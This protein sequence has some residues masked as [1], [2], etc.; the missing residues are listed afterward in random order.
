MTYWLHWN[1]HHWQKNTIEEVKSFIDFWRL[2]PRQYSVE[3]FEA[4]NGYRISPA[5]SYTG[6]AFKYVSVDYNGE[7]D[8]RLGYCNSIE[9]CKK[10]IDELNSELKAA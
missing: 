4:Y 2:D 9:E 3:L 8:N 5:P 1:F 6:Y 7:G 10:Q